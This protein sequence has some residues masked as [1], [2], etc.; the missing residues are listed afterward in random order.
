MFK[1]LKYIFLANLYRK[2][3]KSFTML[4]IYVVSLILV[5]FIINDL[6]SISTGVAVYI[7][8]LIKWVSI[9]SLLSLI[10]FSILKIFNIA[11]NP[12]ES[13]E[14]ETTKSNK[15]KISTDTKK[16]RILAK[17]KLFTQ[18]DLIMQKYMKD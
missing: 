10:G 11:T 18:S 14:N 3:K 8:L 16:D 7:L 2:A 12:F 6:I 15:E 13:K 4:F 5:S 1:A 9:L 17:E